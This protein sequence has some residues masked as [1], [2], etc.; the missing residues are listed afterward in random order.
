MDLLITGGTGFIGQALCRAALERGHG[1]TVL[2][3]NPQAVLPEGV[4]RITALAQ[5]GEAMPDGI[6]N[7]A[8][9]NLGE[10]RWSAAR[11]QA[12]IDSRI[13]T[14]RDLVTM[15]T[16]SVKRPR[17]LVSGSAIGWYGARGSDKLTEESPGGKTSEFQSHLCRAW[18]LEAQKAEDLGVRVCR[19]RTGI[20]LEKDGGPLARMLPP[21]RLGLGGRLGQGLQW[22]S[23]IHRADLV[24]MLLWLVEDEHSS[25]AYNGTA[26]KPE[27][28]IE[29]A[30]LLGEALGRP[31]LMPMPAPI[32]KMMLGEFAQLL[33]TGQRVLPAR[34]QER[35]FAFRYPTLDVA[36][37]AILKG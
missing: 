6:I 35:G 13:N 7:L 32:L 9:Q 19:V 10:G 18:E 36:L 37:A 1:V 17:V 33:L 24:A 28:N 5:L 34:A 22:M 4:N 25:G 30:R 3:R 12:F 8:G 29:F 31:V 27:R 23:W 2:T 20:V 15:M 14:T 26:P 16:G 11:K 21:F